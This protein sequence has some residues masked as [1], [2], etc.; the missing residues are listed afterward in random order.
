MGDRVKKHKISKIIKILFITFFLTIPEIF[1]IGVIK[2][3]YAKLQNA[4]IEILGI[5]CTIFFIAF[6]LVLLG[7]SSKSFI[8]EKI[9]DMAFTCFIIFTLIVFI[10]NIYILF[11]IWHILFKKRLQDESEE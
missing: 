6:V 10:R 5:G 2:G 4:N 1:S 11:K 7:G 9:V 8:T 3:K